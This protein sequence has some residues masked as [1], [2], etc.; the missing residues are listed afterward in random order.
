MA[1]TQSKP[2]LCGNEIGPL[3]E[4]RQ[5]F[6]EGILEIEK[7]AALNQESIRAQFQGSFR[8]GLVD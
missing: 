2:G 4:T 3:K 8:V 1:K 5:H 7:F 6:L